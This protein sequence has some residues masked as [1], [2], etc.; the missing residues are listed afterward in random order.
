MDITK[1]TISTLVESQLPDFIVNEYSN[2]SKFLEKYYEHLE[3][4]GNPLDIINNITKYTNIDFYEKNLLN[5]YT[6]TTQSIDENQTTINVVDT[7]SFPEKNGYI[8]IDDE[9]CFYKQKTDTSFIDVSRGI[10]G[11]TVLGDLYNKSTFITSQSTDHY[12]GSTV[13]NISNLFLYALVKNFEFQYLNGIP[14]KYLKPEVDKKFL[15]KNIGDFYKAKGTETSIKFI[16][17][18]IVSQDPLETVEKYNPKDF[19]LKSSVSDWVSK[20]SIKINL[21]SGNINKV[22]GNKITQTNSDGTYASAVVENIIYSGVSGE[23]ELLLA[24]N[25]INGNFK[26]VSKTILKSPINVSNGVGSRVDVE[27]TVSWPESGSFIVNSEVINYSGKNVNQFIIESRKSPNTNHSVNTPIYSLDRID[28]VYDSERIIFVITG[29][30]YDLIPDKLSPYSSEGDEVQ[31]YPNKSS[32]H[33]IVDQ[34]NW[35]INENYSRISGTIPEISNLLKDVSAIYEDEEFFYVCSSGYSS[36]FSL[37]TNRG[38]NLKDQKNLKLIKKYP[39]VSAEIYETTKRDVGILVDG[40][41]VF[42]YKDFDEVRYGKI[43]DIDVYSKGFGYKSSPYVLVNNQNGKARAILSGEVVDHIIVETDEIFTEDPE[44]TIVSGRNATVIPIVTNGEISSIKIENPGEYYSSPPQIVIRDLNGKGSFAEYEAVISNDGKL[45]ECKKISGGRFYELST[46]IIDIIPVGAN[47]FATAKIKR[48][49]KNRYKNLTSVVDVNNGY[50]FP[51][52]NNFDYG[53]GVIANPKKLRYSLSDNINGA[54]E[55]NVTNFSHS[56]IIGYAYDGNPIYGPYGYSNPLNPSSSIVRMNSGYVLTNNRSNGPSL[57]DYPL[58]TF[59]DDYKW[60]A[61]I[62]SGKTYLDKNNGRFCITPEYPSGTYAYFTTIDSSSSPVFPYIVGENFYSLPVALNYNSD[63]SQDKIPTNSKRILFNQNIVNGKNSTAIVKNI[64][65]GEITSTTIKNSTSHFSVGSDVFIDNE[66]TGGNFA[67]AQVAEVEGKNV[68]DIISSNVNCAQISI[69]KNTYFFKGDIVYQ[70]TQPLNFEIIVENTTV[71]GTRLSTSPNVKIV[72]D[73]KVSLNSSFRVIEDLEEDL[74]IFGEVL[75]DVKDDNTVVLKNIQGEFNTTDKLASTIEVINLILDRSC[76]YTEGAILSLKNKDDNEVASG[77]VLSGTDRQNSVKLKITSGIF[78]ADSN[79]FVKSNIITDTFISNVVSSSTI[80]NQLSIVD[81]NT[82]IAILNTEENHNLGIND[83][84][85]IDITPSDFSTLTQYYVRKRLYQDVKFNDIDFVYNI[86]DSGLGRTNIIN[87]GFGYQ[88][89]TFQN[90]ELIFQDSTLA[91]RNIGLA[92]NSGNARATITVNNGYVTSVQIT[93]KGIGYKIGDILTVADSSLNRDSGAT[94]TFRLAL[95]VDYVG[96]SKQNTKLFLNNINNIANN[97]YIKVGNE[98]LLV[99]SVNLSEKSL[100]VERGQ[101]N[102]EVTDHYDTQEVIPEEVKYNFGTN[103]YPLGQGAGKPVLKQYDK[104]TN[105]AIFVFNYNSTDEFKLSENILVKDQSVPEK[106]VSFSSVEAPKYKLE[107]SKDNINFVTN[108]IIEIQ[109]KYRYRFNTSHFSMIDTYLDF[110]PSINKNIITLEKIIS[111]NVPG[112][113]NS[114]I[115]LKFGYGLGF[116]LNNFNTLKNSDYLKYYYYVNGDDRV[117]TENSYLNLIQDPLEGR[118]NITFVTD[119]EFVYNI[120]KKP[121]YDGSGV[122]KYST[123]SNFAIGKIKNI[124]IASTGQGYKKIPRCPGVLPTPSN[125]SIVDV[126]YDS[127]QQTITSI[128]VLDQGSNYSKPIALITDGDGINYAFNCITENGKIKNVQVLNGGTGFTY[129]PSI[130]IYESDVEIYFNSHNIGIP[131]SIEIYN[132]GNL[133]TNDASTLPSFESI[134]TLKLDYIDDPSYYDGEIIYQY[135]GNNIVASGIVAQNGW[136]RLTNLLKVK[137]LTGIFRK[138]YTI[139]SKISKKSAIVEDIFYSTFNGIIKSILDNKGQFNSQRGRLNSNDQKLSDS[140]FYQD[141]SYVIKSKTPISKWRELILKSIHPAGFNLFGEVVIESDGN[142]S[143]PSAQNH[144][145]S[146]TLINLEPKLIGIQEDNIKISVSESFVSLNNLNV[147]RGIGTVYVNYELGEETVA[148]ELELNKEFNGYYN[149]S[150]GKIVGD[151]TFTIINKATGLPYAPQKEEHLF[152]TIDGILQ[153][154]KKSFIAVGNKLIF[155][156]P[157]LGESI[158]EGQIVSGQKFYGKSISYKD[159]NLNESKIKKIQDISEYFDGKKTEFDLYYEENGND[160]NIVKSSSN[161]NFIVCLNGVLQKAKQS[162]KNPFGNSYHIVRSENPNVTDKIVFSDPPIA[163]ELLY[164]TNTDNSAIKSKEKSFIIYYPGYKRL[165]IDKKSVNSYLTG[166]YLLFDEFSNRI[167]NVDDSIFC[168]VFVD[169]V[170]QIPEQSYEIFGSVIVFNEPIRSY[171]NESD[172]NTTNDVSVLYFYGRDSEYGL[173][174]HDHDPYNF[175]IQSTILLEGTFNNYL[176]ENLQT[177]FN[178]KENHTLTLEHQNKFIGTIKSITASNTV[179]QIVVLSKLFYQTNST[180]YVIKDL[181]VD[182]QFI[183]SGNYEATLTYR[184][185]ANN[186]IDLVRD[187][188]NSTFGT[189]LGIKEYIARN[190]MLSTLSNGDKILIDGENDYREVLD[191]PNF[192]KTKEYNLYKNSTS[193]IYSKLKA[194]NYNGVVQGEG[195]SVRTEIDDQGRVINILW[196]RRDLE[197]Y[198]NKNI[199]TQSTTTKYLIAPEITFV[200]K[201]SFGGGAEAKVIIFNGEIID[202]MI[203]N[204]GYGYSSPPIAYV[205]RGYNVVKNINRKSQSFIDTYTNSNVTYAESLDI[206]SIIN[207]NAPQEGIYPTGFAYTN[208]F[209]SEDNLSIVFEKTIQSISKALPLKV[210][211]KLIERKLSYSSNQQSSII[212]SNTSELIGT[213][214]KLIDKKDFSINKESLLSSKTILLTTDINTN[215][216]DISY[217]SVLDAPVD[218]DDTI[219]YVQNTNNFPE[220]GIVLLGREYIAYERKASDRL[221]GLQRGY[222]NSL[223][224]NHSPGDLLKS[225]V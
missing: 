154:P 162:A 51:S 200:Q 79:Y 133:Y 177:W 156:S 43:V 176:N 138:N 30:L 32:S 122:I 127:N 197:L 193:K 71:T 11:N 22:I 149:S 9:I 123:T 219:M 107:F 87:S 147:Q 119:K 68:V 216:S 186:I 92:G 96:F 73:F 166:P 188:S 167:V 40:S 183:L 81:L 209:N 101:K 18:S 217:C 202:V 163:H 35:Q 19:T 168:L 195:L 14:D 47:A 80:S 115:D 77:I 113:V 48:W 98:I 125:E 169:G 75:S 184:R 108:P 224:D 82:N 44:I 110:S 66:G 194:S 72:N 39:T 54:Y 62:N 70:G 100:I 212:K 139:K 111:N 222:N 86:K 164:D 53:Y 49:V 129:K 150:T 27:S 128:K 90:V 36:S 4:Q 57:V 17:N 157:P 6:K 141:Y 56:P 203:T 223:I 134:I 190:K 97:D 143:M 52:Y 146:T 99:K 142:S 215:I 5:Q 121:Q 211:S 109:N 174:I 106:I 8:L 84:V 187:S 10:S 93:N 181:S 1:R 225:I 15:I 25:S 178:G 69:D 131:T 64:L 206:Y 126:I 34:V 7:A 89:T 137:P 37:T 207:I 103:Y 136:R 196:N 160:S 179:I 155:S 221:I 85:N 210:P 208:Q 205:T 145:E 135:E 67:K 13:L 50:Y 76:T 16:F 26:I 29:I 180:N 2:F 23:Y 199:L 120:D 220:S 192:A 83:I 94:S 161:E 78:F 45:I 218:I 204:P 170:L 33:P 105:S 58:G 28:D 198:F 173:T 74:S 189:E 3:C 21:L 112:S 201:D 20:Y 116:N 118:K 102:T 171:V 63:I 61:N 191:V 182:E 151:T 31:F 140:Y 46:V 124:S 158:V 95:Y 152:I 41:I 159:E 42:S 165:K 38:F 214:F 144:I 12:T 88:S 130:K 104:T 132:N 153:E 117:N 24:P 213:T 59:I 172:Q 65:G 185:D 175:N 91:R 114:Y 60:V 55:E 148:I